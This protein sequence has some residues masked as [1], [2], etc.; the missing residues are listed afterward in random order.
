ML[1]GL[2]RSQCSFHVPEFRSEPELNR[3][4]S[5]LTPD[6]RFELAQLMRVARWG[7]AALRG[8]VDRSAVAVLSLGEFNAL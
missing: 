8:R 1:N 4:V 3:W 2:D 6:Q 5:S 7:V